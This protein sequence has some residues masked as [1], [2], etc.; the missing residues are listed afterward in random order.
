MT[1]DFSYLENMSIKKTYL[2]MLLGGGLMMTILL[3]SWVYL[4]WQNEVTIFTNERDAYIASMMFTIVLIMA[5][6]S[7]II[8][9]HKVGGVR[10]RDILSYQGWCQDQFKKA[11]EKGK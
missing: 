8:I 10:V 7:C 2:L 6:V 1:K 4:N 9:I 5:L 3:G 11:K